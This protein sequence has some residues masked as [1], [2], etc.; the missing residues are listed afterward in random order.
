MRQKLSKLLITG[1][2]GFIGSAFIRHAVSCGFE[3]TVV[4]KLT[5]AGDKIRLKSVKDQI[6]FHKVDICN[7]Q[8]MNDIFKKGRFDAV[9]HIATETHVDGKK[10]NYS[11]QV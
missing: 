7:Q 3:I 9:I 2:A 5:Y 6:S 1:G 10:R 8:K 4:D 11:K